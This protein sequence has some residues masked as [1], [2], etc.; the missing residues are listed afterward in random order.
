MPCLIQRQDEMGAKAKPVDQIKHQEE[1]R[2]CHQEEPV[3][4]DMIF[5]TSLFWWLLL[6]QKVLGTILVWRGHFILE[7]VFANELK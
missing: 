2:H 6:I 3:S 7:I 5:T 4:L 1:A